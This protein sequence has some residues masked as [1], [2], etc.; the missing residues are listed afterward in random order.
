MIDLYFYLIP[1]NE[2]SVSLNG[3]QQCPYLQHR[4][5]YL[6][7]ILISSELLTVGTGEIFLCNNIMVSFHGNCSVLSEFQNKSRC[8]GQNN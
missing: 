5:I 4:N 1:I 3:L 8:S 2:Q 6:L 7:F